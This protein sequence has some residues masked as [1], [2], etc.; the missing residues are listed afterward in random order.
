MSV[1]IEEARMSD[2]PKCRWVASD[3]TRVLAG[4]HIRDCNASGCEGCQPCT[5]RH[6]LSCGMNHAQVTCPGCLDDARTDLFNIGLLVS[7]IEREAP[8][9][10]VESEAAMLAGPAANPEAWRNNAMSILRGRLCGCKPNDCYDDQPMP[11]EPMCAKCK[12]L[13]CQVI[14]GD[15]YRC[16]GKVNYLEDCRDEQHPLWVLGTWEQLWRLELEQ[17]ADRPDANRLSTVRLTNTAL[18]TLAAG[19]LDRLMSLMSTRMEPPFVDFA[20]DLAGCRSH[21]EDVLHDSRKPE[22]GA[23]CPLCEKP[24]E[25]VYGAEEDDDEWV[26]PRASCGQRYSEGDYRAKVTATYRT[27]AVSLTASDLRAEYR[28]S[29]SSVRTWAQRGQVRKRGKD[30]Q[31][32][33][34]YDVEDVLTARGEEAS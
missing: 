14:R 11:L 9:R 32:R 28:V 16:P 13:S 7:R 6:C 33:M 27:K 34:R 30:G 18:I 10:S 21:L 5:E 4:R 17:D 8:H 24:L 20:R 2:E 31:G 26:C 19:Y 15:V 12:H 1:T 3:Q 29:E 23:P 25:H 22:T